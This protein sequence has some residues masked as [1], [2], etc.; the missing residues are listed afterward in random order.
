MDKGENDVE[1]LF[2]ESFRDFEAEVNPGIWKNIQTGLKGAGIG[3]LIRSIF[4]KM[5]S[6]TLVATIS[7]VSVIIATVLIT[8]F[9]GKPKVVPVPVK[10]DKTTVKPERASVKEIK[11]FLTDGKTESKKKL[12]VEPSIK[13][14][15]EKAKALELAGKEKKKI[16][17]VLKSLS[18][19]PAT[20]PASFSPNGDG[21]DDFF[22]F[23]SQNIVNMEVILFDKKGK[24]FFTWKGINGKWDGNNQQGKQANEGTY[25]YIINAEGTAGKKYEQKGAINLTR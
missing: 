4:N 17:D 13:E 19:E 2:K 14:Q 22:V 20:A 11:T 18:E 7:S 5:G 9:T 16:Q 25:Y 21:V 10:P 3:F 12:P 1:D 24:I 6:T 8:N 15:K 23:Q